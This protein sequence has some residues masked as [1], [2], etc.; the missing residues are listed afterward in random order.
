MQHITWRTPKP[1]VRLKDA[2]N[3]ENNEKVRGSGH[4]P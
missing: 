2:S 4:I 3:V 1:L